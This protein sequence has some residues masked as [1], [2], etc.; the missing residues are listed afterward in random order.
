M[1]TTGWFVGRSRLDYGRGLCGNVHEA[2]K[3]FLYFS[4]SLYS[5]SKL[6][7]LIELLSLP[8]MLRANRY[9]LF[10][11]I[12]EMRGEGKLEESEFRRWS[13]FHNLSHVIV[14]II[15]EALTFNSTWCQRPSGCLSAV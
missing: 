13:N 11:V 10:D 14:V 7:E 8:C 2:P 5:S 6:S 4:T 3:R 9:Y 15:I 1:Q 12:H